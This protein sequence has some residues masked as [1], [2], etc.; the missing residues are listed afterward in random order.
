VPVRHVE[1]GRNVATYVTAR[2]CRPAGRLHGPLVVSIRQILEL[3]VST[4]SRVSG[5]MPAVHGGPAHTGDPG[6]P[7]IR[8]L[9][10]PD[11]GDPPDRPWGRTAV[12]G[13]RGHPPAAVM[14]SRP[15]FAIAYAPGKMFVTD[16]RDE[17][18]R[19]A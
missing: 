7:G 15:P 17:E 1:Q 8:D 12:L 3:L 18:Y 13:L 14:A 6:A 19:R 16:I 4:A 11:F 5:L 10:R 9:A 2:Q